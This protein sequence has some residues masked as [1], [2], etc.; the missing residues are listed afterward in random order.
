MQKSPERVPE[1]KVTGPIKQL[2]MYGGPSSPNN[3]NT[4]DFPQQQQ[5][6]MAGAV[7]QL[8]K[9]FNMSEASSSSRPGQL[10]SSGDTSR[11]GSFCSDVDSNSLPSSSPPPSDDSRPLRLPF[12]NRLA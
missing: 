3:D 4:W 5:A 2:P 6:D 7:R 9:Y 1:K 8:N 11:S 12:F 10:N